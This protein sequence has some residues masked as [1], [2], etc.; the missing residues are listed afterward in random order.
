MV[1]SVCLFI[2][3]L[4]LINVLHFMSVHILHVSYTHISIDIF[5]SSFFS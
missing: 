2:V 5:K 4:S 1:P 3:F